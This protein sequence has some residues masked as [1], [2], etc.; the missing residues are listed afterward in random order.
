MGS[1][2]GAGGHAQQGRGG[3]YRV[4]HVQGGFTDRACSARYEDTYQK[5]EDRVTPAPRTLEN[6]FDQIEQGKWR[7]MHLTEFVSREDADVA[8][9][10]AVI[11][12]STGRWARAKHAPEELRVRLD[13]VANAILMC[14]F[15]YGIS[16]DHAQHF[17][18]LRQ[19]PS[20]GARLRSPGQGRQGPQHGA[21]LFRAAVLRVPG[22]QGRH[23]EGQQRAQLGG[24]PGGGHGGHPG[25]GAL[26]DHSTGMQQLGGHQEQVKEP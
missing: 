15:R 10:G 21:A 3:G 22:P 26:P 20:G 2:E 14:A 24:L 13:L 4:Q 8:P 6:L 11:D 1:G 25:E 17:Q 19:P 12:H 23:Q 7:F 9:V 18:P 16:A 5:M